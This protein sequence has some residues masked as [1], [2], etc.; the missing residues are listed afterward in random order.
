MFDPVLTLTNK[1]VSQSRNEGTAAELN[2]ILNQIDTANEPN[3][4]APKKLKRRRRIALV[5]TLLIGAG[6]LWFLIPNHKPSAQVIL[7]P[8]DYSI[9]S[10]PTPI[11]DRWIP[12]TW[13]WL[14][15]LRNAVLG[16]MAVIE[17]DSRIVRL[18]DPSNPRLSA[19]LGSYSSMTESNGVRAWIL[20]E[21]DLR[22]LRQQL[23]GI[24]GYEVIGS[25]RITSGHT[26]QANLLQTTTVAVGDAQ[27]PV[28]VFFNCLTLARGK[29][30]DLT[31]VVTQ[32]EAVTKS[33]ATGASAVLANATQ[34][35]TNIT[36]GAKLQLPTGFGAFLVETNHADPAGRRVGIFIHAQVK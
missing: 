21:T 4:S 14:W 23:E 24:E 17:V 7:L 9:Q 15:R 8:V 28:G 26:V 35:H 6:S 33:P 36:L 25:P 10:P 11:P 22:A 16:K 5:V 31:V 19:A 27:L 2:L 34:I 13:G 3:S 30:V 12:M 29:S 32:S 18:A 1:R 20:P